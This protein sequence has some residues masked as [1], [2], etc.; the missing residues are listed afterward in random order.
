MT[1]FT[2]KVSKI[3]HIRVNFRFLDA[4][5]VK[6]LSFFTQIDQQNIFLPLILHR[7][8]YAGFSKKRY[9]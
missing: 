8:N 1:T 5:V 7:E 6:T 3:C 4:F 2:K 9:R